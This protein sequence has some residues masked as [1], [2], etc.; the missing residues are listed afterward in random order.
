MHG[1][2]QVH[3]LHLAVRVAHAMAGRKPS[4][5]P[6][7]SG[8]TTSHCDLQNALENTRRLQDLASVE[9]PREASLWSRTPSSS[10]PSPCHQFRCG[11]GGGGAGCSSQGKY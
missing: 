9:Y 7:Q 5:T 3:A 8:S 11:W 2:K 1:P 6:S 4:S 10:A